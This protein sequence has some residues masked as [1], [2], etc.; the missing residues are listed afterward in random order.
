MCLI[1]IILTT[2]LISWDDMI[3]SVFKDLLQKNLI[4]DIIVLRT[5]PSKGKPAQKQ[6]GS[7]TVWIVSFSY[8]DSQ[9]SVL[10]A[11]RGGPREWASLSNLSKW[12]EDA[13]VEKYQV[14]FSIDYDRLPQPTLEFVSSI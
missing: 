3:E 14:D 7:K 11:S 8:G 5:V 13:G 10:E 2:L 12:L 1:Y 9:Q 4:T 6:S